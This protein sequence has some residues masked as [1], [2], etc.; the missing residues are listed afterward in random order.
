M[1][2]AVIFFVML[3]ALTVQHVYGADEHGRYWI[4]GVGKHS[5]ATF[6]R[7]IKG[8]RLSYVAYKGWVSGYL[9]SSNRLSE[10]TYNLLGGA[11]FQSALTWLESYC[12]KYPEN[13]LYM[14]LANM[15]AVFYPDRKKTK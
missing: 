7:E 10:E 14:A 9:T 1:I 5:C 4:Y 6:T 11:G 8:N 15:T 2:K 3:Y 13:T 12:K